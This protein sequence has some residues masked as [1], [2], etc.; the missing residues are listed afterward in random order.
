MNIRC[1]D[2]TQ[3]IDTE[4][5]SKNQS[6]VHQIIQ[7]PDAEANGFNAAGTPDSKQW[8]SVYSLPQ[9]Y[10]EYR[11][12]WLPDRVQFYLDGMLTFILTDDIPDS[13]GHLLLSHWSNG[14]MGWSMGP[15]EEDAV[16]AVSYIK[17][18][19]NTT[20]SR[21][22]TKPACKAVCVV[23]EQM[24]PP[25]PSNGETPFFTLPSGSGTAD[26]PVSS[27]SSP[28]HGRTN[29]AVSEAESMTLLKEGSGWRTCGCILIG[30]LLH[31]LSS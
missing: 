30:V 10:H 5:L 31:L 15:P 17:A 22:A 12:D 21:N 18:Y 27:V 26:A 4:V 2:D 28:P 3:E 24:N 13:P 11:F 23:P 29:S 25:D 20:G 1:S 6:I 8:N 7:T 19:F 14:N 16:M 9:D